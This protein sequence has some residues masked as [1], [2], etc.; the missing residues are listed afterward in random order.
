M[1]T[2]VRLHTSALTDLASDCM[3]ILQAAKAVAAEESSSEE[4]SSDEESSDDE[5][6]LHDHLLTWSCFAR[7]LFWSASV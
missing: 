2:L 1:F 5:V 4:E 7:C 3:Y 6:G